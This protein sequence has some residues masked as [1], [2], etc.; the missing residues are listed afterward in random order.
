MVA[1][2]A[3]K[4]GGIDVLVN[5]AGISGPTAPVRD[6]DPDPRR[7]G[8]ARRIPT[9]AL[10]HPKQVASIGEEQLVHRFH[11]TDRL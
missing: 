11:K 5:N 7:V 2:A 8:L 4:L 3:A 10:S 1:D 6:V 9:A